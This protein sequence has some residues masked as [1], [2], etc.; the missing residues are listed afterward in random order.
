MGISIQCYLAQE[1]IP[2]I[3]PL[4][5]TCKLAILSLYKVMETFLEDLKY[6]EFACK[7]L[8]GIEWFHILC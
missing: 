3:L 5:A 8:K 7:G 6:V 4:P 1:T 2:C